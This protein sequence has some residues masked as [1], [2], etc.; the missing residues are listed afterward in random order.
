MGGVQFPSVMGARL[1]STTLSR[2]MRPAQVEFPHENADRRPRTEYKPIGHDEHYILT[3]V[4]HSDWALFT[5][6]DSSRAVGRQ[7]RLKLRRR[8]VRPPRQTLQKTGSAS[9]ARNPGR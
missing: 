6:H 2:G 3:V 4:A 7:L 1:F 5:C 8:S 9:R